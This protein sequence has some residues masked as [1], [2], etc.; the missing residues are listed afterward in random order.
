MSS[1]P[2]F[3]LVTSSFCKPNLLSD[4]FFRPSVGSLPPVLSPVSLSLHPKNIAVSCTE[5]WLSADGSCIDSP[6]YAE[7]LAR[8]H[9]QW[10]CKH[11]A[12][13]IPLIS[14]LLPARSS[15]GTFQSFHQSFIFLLHPVFP[16]TLPSVNLRRSPRHLLKSSSACLSASSAF[17][18]QFYTF[19]MVAACYSLVKRHKI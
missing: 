3:P 12:R 8:S 6:I 19:V 2:P 4:S 17:N 14:P 16:P 7:L 11:L 18:I 5:L 10:G 1:K 15:R 9:L 13:R